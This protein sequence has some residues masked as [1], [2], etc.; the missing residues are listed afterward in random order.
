MIKQNYYKNT[1]NFIDELVIDYE[2]GMPIVTLAEKFKI[3]ITTVYRIRDAFGLKLRRPNLSEDMS[4]KII[5]MYND[6]VGVKAIAK[7][8]GIARST[9]FKCLKKNG[10]EFEIGTHHKSKTI[11]YRV[12]GRMRNRC[13][14]KNNADY[15]Y[16]GERGIKVCDRWMDK[17][18]GFTN[19]LAD[20]GK[21]PVGFSIERKDFNGDYC[22]ENC[23]WIP[24]QDQPKNTRRCRFFELGGI[25]RSLQEWCRLFKVKYRTVLSRLKSGKP[26]IDCLIPE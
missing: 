12:F 4:N 5:S 15:K 25:T 22:P 8:L 11:E 3:D 19:F 21:M 10:I 20:M 24:K 18:N 26:F 7:N 23:I 16:Y 1:Y 14:N 17:D 2:S 13:N 9:V 6:D